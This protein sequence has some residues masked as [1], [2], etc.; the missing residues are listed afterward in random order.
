MGPKLNSGRGVEQGCAFEHAPLARGDG[1]GR[2]LVDDDALIRARWLPRWASRVAQR[3]TGAT[4]QIPVIVLSAAHDVQRHA[5]G[6]D[7]VASF[8]KPFVL[9]ALLGAIAP[10]LSAVVGA[11]A[12]G[13]TR[14]S[15]A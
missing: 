10:V 13:E 14:N 11:S 3:S 2:V 12:C 7:R 4:A 6:L 8:A 5:S 1:T 15:L 9:G